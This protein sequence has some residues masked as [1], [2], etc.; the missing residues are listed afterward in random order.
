MLISSKKHL[1]ITRIQEK[2]MQSTINTFASFIN[3]Q[4]KT[5]QK[6]LTTLIALAKILLLT[7]TIIML[8]IATMLGI[9]VLSIFK[10]N[11][12][13]KPNTKEIP[14]LVGATDKE[15]EYFEP[16]ENPWDSDT[17]IEDRHAPI[18]LSIDF[19]EA[20]KQPLFLL[21]PAPAVIEIPQSNRPKAKPKKQEK[22][23][24]PTKK[25]DKDLA[26]ER[27][28]KHFGTTQN[29]KKNFP[30]LNLKKPDSWIEIEKAL[31]A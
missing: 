25:S 15:I 17:L 24:Q 5:T 10:E 26:K 18:A 30:N 11:L 14:V 9:V 29:V 4:E 13:T 23:K 22:T 3:N 12:A 16:L 28:L 6:V 31:V 20:Q 21:P 8:A 19:Q 27:V 1:N 2:I 7:T